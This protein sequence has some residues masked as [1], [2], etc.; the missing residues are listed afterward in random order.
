MKVQESNRASINQNV[1]LRKFMQTEIANISAEHT[2][3][4]IKLM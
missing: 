4:F 3:F 1:E 2:T